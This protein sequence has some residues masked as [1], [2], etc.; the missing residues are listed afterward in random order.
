MI[1]RSWSLSLVCSAVLLCAACAPALAQTGGDRV[2]ADGFD[3]LR[4]VV[5]VDFLRTW[6][7][8]ARGDNANQ[9][10]VGVSYERG[11]SPGMSLEGTVLVGWFDG[12][13]WGDHPLEQVLDGPRIYGIELVVRQYTPLL[14]FNGW[15]AGVAYTHPSRSDIDNY[16]VY[17]TGTVLDRTHLV[18]G[19]FA[20]LGRSAELDLG[21]SYSLTAKWHSPFLREGDYHV[22]G[23]TIRVGFGL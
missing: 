18:A 1:M 11:F 23:F 10:Y 8:E 16:Y 19:V 5:G 7:G 12:A 14:L 20:S 3:S 6:A 4:I 21:L 2:P 17:R 15:R 22:A 13:R 9:Y